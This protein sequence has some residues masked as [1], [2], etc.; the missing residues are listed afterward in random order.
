MLSSLISYRMNFHVECIDFDL[1]YLKKYIF[2][3]K[4]FVD[5]PHSKTLWIQITIIHQIVPLL[6][7]LMF[8]F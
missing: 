5:N 4:M 7:R 8:F 6:S 1:S 2:S 3:L